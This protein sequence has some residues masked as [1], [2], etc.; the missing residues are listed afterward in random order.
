MTTNAVYETIYREVEIMGEIQLF[1][2]VFKEISSSY[3]NEA[4]L[5]Y[6]T[7]VIGVSKTAY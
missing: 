6:I 1:M 7:V 3:L 4:I 5:V 2:R